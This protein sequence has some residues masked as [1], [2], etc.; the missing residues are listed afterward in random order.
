M[1]PSLKL[2][3]LVALPCLVSCAVANDKDSIHYRISVAPDSRSIQITC[4][5]VSAGGCVFWIGDPKADSHRS[6]R[7]AAGATE[8]LGAE[9]FDA[10]YC[11]AVREERL[12]WPGCLSG[13]TSGALSRDTSV[14][15]TFW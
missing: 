11:A 3:C 4:S 5:Q 15:Y 8:H 10:H 6:V 2:L 7:L 1:L 13:P 9:A 14:D 12:A